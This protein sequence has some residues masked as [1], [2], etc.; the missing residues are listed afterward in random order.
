MEVPSDIIYENIQVVGVT[1]F[2]ELFLKIII[3]GF[4]NKLLYNLKLIQ[5][6]PIFSLLS[7]FENWSMFFILIDFNSMP[8]YNC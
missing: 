7:I 8:T 2:P 4:Q 5:A 1:T 3:H 6:Q